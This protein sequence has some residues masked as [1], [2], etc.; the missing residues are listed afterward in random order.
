[1]RLKICAVGICKDKAILQ[2]IAEYKKRLTWK[3]EICEIPNSNAEEESYNLLKQADKDFIILLD[4]KGKEYDSLE[5]SRYME[6]LMLS[7]S[8]ISFL[9]GGAGGHSSALKSKSIP[10]IS[11]SRMTMPHML[12]RVF[13]VEQLYRAESIIKAHPYHK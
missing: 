6:N 11:L 13:L 10:Q 12:A 9:I 1:M 4:E 7:Q 5:F 3:L 2:L 8:R